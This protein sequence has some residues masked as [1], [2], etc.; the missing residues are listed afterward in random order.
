[1]K[2]A[3]NQWC[4]PEGTP[5]NEV[6]SQ[7]KNA[8]FDGVELNVNAPDGVGLTTETSTAQARVIREIR[9]MLRSQSGSNRT[10]GYKGTDPRR[11]HRR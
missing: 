2:R 7:S 9:I 10:I 3:V 4:F 5:I 11:S 1:M 8:G 6:F